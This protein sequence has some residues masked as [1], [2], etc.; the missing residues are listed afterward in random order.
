MQSEIG[1]VQI[2]VN[3][4]FNSPLI[5]FKSQL[6]FLILIL[7]RELLSGQKEGT[8]EEFRQ[9]VL[10]A[11]DKFFLGTRT[12]RDKRFTELRLN[13]ITQQK[14]GSITCI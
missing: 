8:R 1:T 12:G 6:I 3:S 11:L 5:P 7:F 13:E 9:A 2:T 10:L 14:I 4:P